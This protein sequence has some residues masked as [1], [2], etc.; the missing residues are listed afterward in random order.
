M[1]R[2]QPWSLVGIMEDDLEPGDTLL[3]WR[4][5]VAGQESGSGLRYVHL[6][7]E[8]ELIMLAAESGFKVTGQFRSDGAGEKLGLYQVWQKS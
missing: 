7:N 5:T 4:H 6:F 8:D 2:V 3:D 1:S